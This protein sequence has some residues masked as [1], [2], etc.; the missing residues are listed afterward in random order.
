MKHK[1]ILPMLLI[2]SIFLTSCGDFTSIKKNQLV[3]EKIGKKVTDTSDIVNDK[4]ILTEEEAKLKTLEYLEKYFNVKLY[5][6]EIE[7]NVSFIS[8]SMVKKNSSLINQ[9]SIS[10]FQL[11]YSNSV[12]ENGL[13]HVEFFTKAVKQ[14]Q[15][16]NS[17]YFSMKI[18][19]KTGECI[20]FNSYYNDLYGKPSLKNSIDIN[21]AKIIAEEFI[22]K[23]NIGNIK[24][25]K[26]VNQIVEYQESYNLVFEDNDAGDKKVMISIDRNTKKITGFLVGII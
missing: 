17:T 15:D 23:N 12:L 20:Y 8:S 25:V 3:V 22:L 2:F 18:D 26:F 19:S 1:T 10:K 24:N 21:K 14:A 16:I 9:S 4:K 11:K 7:S 5:M 13:Y 6:S